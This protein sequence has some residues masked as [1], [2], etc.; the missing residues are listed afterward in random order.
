MDGSF[1][2]N[3]SLALG[4]GDW[5]HDLVQE[6]KA[7]SV[8]VRGSLQHLLRHKPHTIVCTELALRGP[9]ELPRGGKK[10]SEPKSASLPLAGIMCTTAEV[11]W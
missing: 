8:I 7:A 4:H 5:P 2:G 10:P 9:E 1:S 11:A 6:V 3:Y